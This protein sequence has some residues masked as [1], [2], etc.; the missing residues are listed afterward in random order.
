MDDV[1]ALVGEAR[2]W[3]SALEARANVLGNELK[4]P[5]VA[6]RF[7]EEGR[8]HELATSTHLITRLADALSA[9]ASSDAEERD[10]VLEEAAKVA[11]ERGE[12]WAHTAFNDKAGR[13]AK[14][15]AEVAMI[16]AEEIATAILSLRTKASDHE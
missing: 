13:E 14:R 1:K 5:G 4:R 15:I 8:H 11:S 9:R 3:A 12:M 2:G 7:A 10:A 6:D 16:E